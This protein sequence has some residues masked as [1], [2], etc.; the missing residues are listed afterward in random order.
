VSLF[1]PRSKDNQKDE[2]DIDVDLKD[3][4][5]LDGVLMGAMLFILALEPI[6]HNVDWYAKLQE[7][8]KWTTLASTVM[9]FGAFSTSVIGAF[10]RK[11]SY[12]TRFKFCTIM[13]VVGVIM[14]TVTI[15]FTVYIRYIFLVVGQ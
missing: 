11:S 5:V 13:T 8:M 15:A 6:S 3:L 12:E 14:L 10:S 2:K 9:S 1:H 7:W 4:L